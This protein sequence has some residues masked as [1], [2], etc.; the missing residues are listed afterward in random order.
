MLEVSPRTIKRDIAA[1]QQSGA[2]IWA[3]AGRGGGYALAGTA[4]LPPVNFT[5]AQAVAVTIAVAA[6]PAGSPFSADATSALAKLSDALDPVE[7]ARSHA[8]AERVWLRTG[9]RDEPVAD[10]SVL[11]AV[12]SA[13]AGSRV[14]AITHR[15]AG[16]ELT[17]RLVEPVLLGWSDGRW[18]LVAWCRLREGIRWFRLGRIVRADLT[19]ASFRPRDVSEV[20]EPPA[21]AGSA[22]GRL[23][24]DR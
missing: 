3:Q 23:R 10:P 1:L 2:P 18:Y 20:G 14:L 13:L 6:L 8:L 12:E 19:H 21:D 11:R 16:G 17:R 4:S 15:S 24:A 7:R 22:L 5:P 9:D